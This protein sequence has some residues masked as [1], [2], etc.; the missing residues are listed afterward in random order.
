MA[1]PGRTNNQG[2][3]GN[4]GRASTAAKLSRFAAMVRSICVMSG[5]IPSSPL[6][7]RHLALQSSTAA[8]AA[9]SAGSAAAEATD[10]RSRVRASV[11]AALI[12][13]RKPT[14]LPIRALVMN[15]RNS[16]IMSPPLGARLNI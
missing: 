6:P 12:T 8:R 13:S 2:K 16:L 10:G 5:R 3:S 14:K 9:R 15:G 7:P 11:S 1:T 4:G